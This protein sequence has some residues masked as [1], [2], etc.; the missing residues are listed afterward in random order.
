M[1]EVMPDDALTIGSEATSS[2]P[3]VCP[4][5]EYSL[6]G[7]KSEG[8]CPECGAQYD[9]RRIKRAKKLRRQMRICNL[10]LVVP[11]I[12]LLIFGI[13]SSA[14]VNNRILDS[15][16]IA[17][18]VSLTAWVFIPLYIVANRVGL[19]EIRHGLRVS[20]VAS[21]GPALLYGLLWLLYQFESIESISS[22]YRLESAILAGPFI[23][24]LLA[25]IR[26]GES[27]GIKLFNQSSR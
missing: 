20:L 14:L 9:E 8:M 15:I 7:M 10:F 26:F 25:S 4:W 18:F 5:C 2:E 1:I 21:L 12:C 17:L 19:I 6:Q 16:F 22:A 3:L 11:Y 24:L 27:L 23:F 13:V